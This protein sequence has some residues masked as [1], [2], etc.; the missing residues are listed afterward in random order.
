MYQFTT[1][2]KKTFCSRLS[3]GSA[4]TPQVPPTLTFATSNCS[5]RFPVD[6]FETLEQSV[7]D[8]GPKNEFSDIY[9]LSYNLYPIIGSGLILF[10][11]VTLLII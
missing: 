10:I 5:S 8:F 11:F 3:L 9:R 2:I 6:D 1:F 7:S 4:F